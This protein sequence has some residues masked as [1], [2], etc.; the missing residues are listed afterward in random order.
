VVVCGGGAE[1]EALMF[2][3]LGRRRADMTSTAAAIASR[4]IASHLHSRLPSPRHLRVTLTGWS[5][6]WHR[7]SLRPFTA[8]IVTVRALFPQAPTHDLSTTDGDCRDIALP[9]SPA[10]ST[11]PA[12]I[13][14]VDPAPRRQSESQSRQR[15]RD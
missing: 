11:S 1:V 2:F 13:R 10:H 6:L 8:I 14:H 7:A 12:H 5:G 3:E 15:H 4:R 9:G